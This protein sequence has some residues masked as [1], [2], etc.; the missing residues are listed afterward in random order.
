MNSW[1]EVEYTELARYPEKYE[2][3]HIKISGQVVQVMENGNYC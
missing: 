3:E 2:G 1:Y